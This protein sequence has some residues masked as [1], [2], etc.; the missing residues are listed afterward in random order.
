[1]LI[2]INNEIQPPHCLDDSCI[3]PELDSDC[4][5][6]TL[7]NVNVFRVKNILDLILS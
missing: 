5:I 4:F 2:V 7:F 6:I 1:M 3:A